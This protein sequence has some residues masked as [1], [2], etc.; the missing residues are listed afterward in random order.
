MKNISK[1]VVI[2]TLFCGGCFSNDYVID[3]VSKRE[4]NY[5]TRVCTENHIATD[6]SEWSEC[7][8]EKGA[9]RWALKNCGETFLNT[10]PM[11]YP[12]VCSMADEIN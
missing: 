6:S 1:F 7:L 9:A 8:R 5:A 4:V 12:T 2:G 3:Q 10:I 11:M